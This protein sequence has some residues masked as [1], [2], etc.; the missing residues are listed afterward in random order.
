MYAIESK[1]SKDSDYYFYMPSKLGKSLFLYPVVV[2]HYTYKAGYSMHRS[3]LENYQL[4]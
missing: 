1:V 3:N 2:G 4:L